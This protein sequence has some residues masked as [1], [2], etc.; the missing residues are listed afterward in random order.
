MCPQLLS[1]LFSIKFSAL[2]VLSF[3]SKLT[4]EHLVVP[5]PP[6]VQLHMCT[7]A[8]CAHVYGGYVYLT[9][10]HLPL[11]LFLFQCACA[12][13]SYP[14][15]TYASLSSQILLLLIPYGPYGI[16]HFTKQALMNR[17]MKY[18]GVLRDTA[19]APKPTS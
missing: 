1:F 17:I 8:H 3:T 18:F 16:W 4:S 9:T 12:R 15:L 14:S 13:Y 2:S 7:C 10:A 6:V 5:N 19:R 11:L